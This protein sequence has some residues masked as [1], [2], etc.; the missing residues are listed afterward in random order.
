MAKSQ[1]VQE[2]GSKLACAYLL[3]ARNRMA[4]GAVKSRQFTPGDDEL[5]REVSVRHFEDGFTI[6]EQAGNWRTGKKVV[7][8]DSRTILV[9]GGSDKQH[10]SWRNQIVAHF[11]QQ[12]LIRIDLGRATILSADTAKL[13]RIPRNKA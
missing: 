1:L 7:S 8:E 3:G 11:Q 13:A 9:V 2:A 6:I 10:R 4:G 5:L 12:S